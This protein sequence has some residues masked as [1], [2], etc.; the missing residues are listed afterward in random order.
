MAILYNLALK[1]GCKN[2]AHLRLMPVKLG[3]NLGG[4]KFT[5]PDAR[6][7]LPSSD[8]GIVPYSATTAV[9]RRNPGVGLPGPAESAA[10]GAFHIDT[11][12]Q[13][14]RRLHC[15]PPRG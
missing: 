15:A 5:R 1:V 14:P 2:G 13:N 11:L 7:C 12:A 3:L 10:N 8:K 4:R 6:P 9:T